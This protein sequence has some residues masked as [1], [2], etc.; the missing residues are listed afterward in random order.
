MNAVL[1]EAQVRQSRECNLSKSSCQQLPAGAIM[2][3]EGDM[4]VRHCRYPQGFDIGGYGYCF[5]HLAQ[6]FL[7]TP[8]SSPGTPFGIISPGAK[9]DGPG[10]PD[11]LDLSFAENR[12][13]ENFLKY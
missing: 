10:Y 8:I 3:L 5:S 2:F 1:Y 11:R 13:G 9:Y 12:I 7:Q 6:Y 4:L